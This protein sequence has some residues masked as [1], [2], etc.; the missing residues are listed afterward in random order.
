MGSY[1]EYGSGNNTVHIDLDQNTHNGGGGHDRLI[2][3]A[4]NEKSGLQFGLLN[5]LVESNMQWETYFEYNKIVAYNGKSKLPKESPLS[6]AYIAE[7]F[8]RYDESLGHF[9]YFSVEEKNKYTFYEEFEEVDIYGTNHND[10]IPY[11]NGS[12]YHGGDG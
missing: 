12:E 6:L 7:M 9:S 2:L 1:I 3:H 8:A 11:L 5:I 10:F 4:R